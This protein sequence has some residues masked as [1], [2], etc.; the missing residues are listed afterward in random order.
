MSFRGVAAP[1][2]LTNHGSAFPALQTPDE[3]LTVRA[4]VA[5]QPGSMQ[6]GAGDVVDPLPREVIDCEIDEVARELC[7][8]MCWT[9]DIPPE[10]VFRSDPRLAQYQFLFKDYHE[11]NPTSMASILQDLAW[12]QDDI[13]DE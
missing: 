7:F 13:E 2:Q 12:L 4:P 11:R 10:W 1:C 6:Q 3:E 8:L 9:T 5:E